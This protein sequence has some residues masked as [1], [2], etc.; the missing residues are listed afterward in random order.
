MKIKIRKIS[1]VI[2]SVAAVV[3][4]GT[5]AMAADKISGGK[6]DFS[7]TGTA[8]NAASVNGTLGNQLCIYCH[9]PHN[10]GQTRYLW[11]KAGNGNTT[12]KLYTSSAT[13]SS[14]VKNQSALTADSP[15]LI[16]LS[17]H[18]GKTAMNV[19]HSGGQGALASSVG[20]LS[21]YP[22]G[23]AL[24]YGNIPQYMPGYMFGDPSGPAI[25]TNNDL[26]NDH[27]IGFS[28]TDAQAEKK[29]ANLN[30]TIDS[31]L[32]LFGTKKKVECSTCHNPHAD[33]NDATLVP[34]LVMPNANSAL[35]LS[36][37]NK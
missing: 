32:R 3:L 10:A 9:T 18:D 7:F 34:F 5:L 11:N 37:H 19:L 20:G 24:A 22:A 25:G 21:G 27:P 30:L 33:S 17:C 15:S 35:C 12:F 2:G 28:Y 26:T 1:V 4:L 8:A 14:V 31:R 29:A 6:H 36:C 13:L 16:C 23:A